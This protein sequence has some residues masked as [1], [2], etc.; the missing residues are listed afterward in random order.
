MVCIVSPYASLGLFYWAWFILFHSLVHHYWA[1]LVL[2][3]FTLH[4]FFLTPS[5]DEQMKLDLNILLLM[6]Y[7]LKI[8]FTIQY[9]IGFRNSV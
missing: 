6:N 4:W 8:M 5:D 9:N 3:Q 2:L 7:I 1:L